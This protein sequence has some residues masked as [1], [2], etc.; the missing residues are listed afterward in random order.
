MKKE[1]AKKRKKNIEIFIVTD[2]NAAMTKFTY[3]PSKQL[4][5][6]TALCVEPETVGLTLTIPGIYLP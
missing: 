1:K 2:K 4:S 6:R 5:R 3:V